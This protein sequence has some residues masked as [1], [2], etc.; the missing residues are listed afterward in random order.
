MFGGLGWDI[1]AGCFNLIFTNL[2]GTYTNGQTA[3]GIGVKIS[4]GCTG[5]MISGLFT[6][7]NVTAD[8]SVDPSSTVYLDSMTWMEG[9]VFTGG[10]TINQA[11]P[12]PLGGAPG[13]ESLRVK[14]AGVGQVNRWEI[15]AGNTAGNGVELITNGADV[16]VPGYIITK[17]NGPLVIQNNFGGATVSVF[18]ASGPT[19]ATNYVR[20]IAT[21]AG[22]PVVTTNAG[23][24]G[25]GSATG[26]IQFVGAQSSSA[27]GSVATALGSLGPA[28]SHPVVQEWLTVVT[29]GGATR[30]IPCASENAP[31]GR[32][33]R[34]G[35][36]HHEA[37]LVAI[38]VL[39][40]LH[41]AKEIV[42]DEMLM[43]IITCLAS[44]LGLYVHDRLR[45]RR[46]D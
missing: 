15:S 11:Q 37:G 27:N 40:V 45:R 1:G 6:N 38:G 16:N 4:G 42:N 29:P 46:D 34:A 21:A 20:T 9:R 41:G 31:L 17:G 10:G 28:G 36:D 2:W 18:S 32:G 44:V 7:S 24:L 35:G 25:L 12:T 13:N 33:R 22:A 43:A 39:V 14:N 5:I 23:N 8:L 30:Y 19:N 3:P 26:L